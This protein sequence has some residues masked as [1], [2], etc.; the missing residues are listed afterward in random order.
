MA[1]PGSDVLAAEGDL[2][3][4]GAGDAR[5]ADHGQV[6]GFQALP[7]GCLVASVCEGSGEHAQEEGDDTQQRKGTADGQL[8]RKGGG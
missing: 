4:L 7:L 3:C 1:V 2:S 5:V 8:G 6:G